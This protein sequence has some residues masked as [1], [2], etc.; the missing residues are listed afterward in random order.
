[1]QRFVTRLGNLVLLETIRNRSVANAPYPSKRL[2]LSARALITARQVGEQLESWRPETLAARQPQMAR[3][4]I[5]IWRNAQLA[6]RS[7]SC[8]VTQPMPVRPASPLPIRPACP[9]SHAL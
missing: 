1:M 6:S 4:I 7:T 9:A 8:S 3:A 5:G 2:G